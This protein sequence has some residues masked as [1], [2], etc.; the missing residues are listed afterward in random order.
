VN[1]CG[2]L[3]G[4]KVEFGRYQGVTGEIGHDGVWQSPTGFSVVVEVKTTDIYAIK[5]ATLLNYVDRLISEK[6]ISDRDSVLGLYVVARI[7]PNVSHLTSTIIAEK[8]TSQL[9]I[10]SID[11]LLSL[12]ELTEDSDV[13][14]EE[15]LSLLRPGGPVVDDIVKLITRVVSQRGAVADDGKTVAAEPVAPT[16]LQEATPRPQTVESRLFLVTP[17]ADDEEASAER[18]IRS[19]LDQGWYVFGDRTP[20]RKKLKVDDR[21]CFYESGVGVVAE[22]TVCSE[23]ERRQI[24]FVRDPTRF[25]WAFRVK[26]VRYFFDKPIVIDASLRARL[27]A[28][29]EREPGNAW[30]W[31]VQATRL[32]TPHDFEVLVGLDSQ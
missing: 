10:L 1:H 16:P 23:P 12:A 7:E 29:R 2:V 28:F 19:L 22:A 14:H 5:T 3:L 8:R 25:P 26:D 9:R 6:R 17:V 31:F 32:V 13:T 24:E 18:T 30:A 21:I 27:D 11:S 4:F 20:G 15:V